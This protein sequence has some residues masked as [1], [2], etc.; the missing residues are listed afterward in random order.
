M[1]GQ[2]D[3]DLRPL[4]EAN[5]YQWRLSYWFVRHRDQTRR[6]IVRVLVAVDVLLLGYA[7]IAALPI[8]RNPHVVSE[9]AAA[10]AALPPITVARPQSISAGPVAQLPSGS[11]S[12]LVGTLTNPNE[13]RVAAEVRY[14][15]S[16]G[17]D[18]GSPERTTW[19]E[20]N[21]TRYVAELGAAVPSSSIVELKVAG[22]RFLR[23]SNR[24]M[25]R[26]DWELGSVQLDQ[27]TPTQPGRV[28]FTVTNRNPF[29]V[30][31]A[32]FLVVILGGGRQPV[33]AT[34][35][36]LSNISPNEQR[37]AVAPLYQSAGGAAEAKVEPGVSPYAEGAW[38]FGL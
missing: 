22:V 1:P 20:P 17:P 2:L 8:L 25:A 14:Y 18:Q 29:T 37:T 32:S 35:V 30:R 19:L 31:R 11:L 38:Y 34:A 13:D 16:Y 12:D 27:P 28:S 6:W 21:Q 9:S 10:I 24:P 33:G 36:E 5:P 7:A 3:G 15:F 23:A 26:V 4:P